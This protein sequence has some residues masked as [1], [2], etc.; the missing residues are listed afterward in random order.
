M[1]KEILELIESVDPSD[2]AKLDE[3]DARV[4]CWLKNK[5][6]VEQK[7]VEYTGGP[8]RPSLW[9][10]RNGKD[11]F[12]NK[13]LLTDYL[14][15]ENWEYTRSRDAL[16]A[17]RPE[18][19]VFYSSSSIPEQLHGTCYCDKGGKRICDWL[20]LN[21]KFDERDCVITEELAELHAIIQAIAFEREQFIKG[22]A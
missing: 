2:T 1:I 9:Y 22:K 12:W 5:E 4:W 21:K 19:W 16:K 20:E 6:I 14:E 10:F 13:T 3:I 18:G 15:D 17:I 8:S 11:G 7:V